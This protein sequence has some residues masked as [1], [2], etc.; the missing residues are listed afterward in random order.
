MWGEKVQQKVF[1]RPQPFSD[2]VKPVLQMKVVAGKNAS[3]RLSRPRADRWAD[4]QRSTPSTPPSQTPGASTNDTQYPVTSDRCPRR[5]LASPLALKCEHLGDLTHENPPAPSRNHV[6]E[7]DDPRSVD[8]SIGVRLPAW[9]AHCSAD[10][11]ALAGTLL[12]APQPI[13]RRPR[14]APGTICSGTLQHGAQDVALW[15][16]RA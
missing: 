14:S 6:Q 8:G 16:W 12:G 4:T 9:C 1:I 11:V 5:A 7:R 13:H 2:A 15:S 3:L 10:G